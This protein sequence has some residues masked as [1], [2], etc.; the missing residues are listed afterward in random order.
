[1]KP[2]FIYKKKLKPSKQLLSELQ[3]AGFICIP[4]EVADDIKITVGFDMPSQNAMFLL[5]AALKAIKDDPH[6]QA[7]R[8]LGMRLIAEAE[9]QLQLM[10]K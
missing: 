8:Q 3:A 4:V 2:L 6:K 7:E 5:E 10:K 9:R 1:M